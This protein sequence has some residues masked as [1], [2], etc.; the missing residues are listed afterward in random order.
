MLFKGRCFRFLGDTFK[1][2]Q[3]YNGYSVLLLKQALSVFH[4]V[5]RKIPHCMSG[6][7]SR[8]VSIVGTLRTVCETDGT[9]CS[10]VAL[11]FV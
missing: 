6:D 8:L 11:L 9:P 7:A 5:F 4:P 3:Y 1:A 2:I 10:P